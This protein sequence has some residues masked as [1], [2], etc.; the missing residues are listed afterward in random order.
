MRCSTCGTENAPDSRFCGG[1]GA[2]LTALESRVAPTHKMSGE[3]RYDSMPPI[4][5]LRAPDAAMAPTAYA[6]HPS[7]PPSSSAPYVQRPSNSAPAGS[8]PREL[9]E[10]G[11]TDPVR[12]MTP[13]PGSVAAT[14]DLHN[15]PRTVEPAQRATPAP[16]PGPTPTPRPAGSQPPTHLSTSLPVAPRTRWGLIAI[17]LVFDLGLAGTGAVLLSEGLRSDAVRIPAPDAGSAVHGELA[18]PRPNVAARVAPP[19]VP[20]DPIK[21][22]VGAAVDAAQAHAQPIFDDCAATATK[23]LPADQALHGAVTIQ[24]SVLADGHIVKAAAVDND[25]GSTQ[26][27]ACL[28]TE[29]ANWVLPPHSGDPVLITR[30]ITFNPQATP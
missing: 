6:P 20:E 21:A 22:Q 15:R 27:G 9:F 13:I 23:A 11:S 5:P 2:K 17:V 30:K 14:P 8:T 4:A 29:I 24:F 1:C 3:A 12:L 18:K 10:R 25:T 7:S 26:L 19:A 28:A 16:A